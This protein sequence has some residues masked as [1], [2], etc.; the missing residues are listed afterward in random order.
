MKHIIVFLEPKDE[1]SLKRT[2]YEAITAA[3]QTG[4][5]ITGFAVSGTETALQSAA[6]YGLQKVVWLSIHFLI[7]IPQ[8]LFLKLY[9]NLHH[10]FK[11]IQF[12]FQQMPQEKKLH[13]ELALS[14]MQ[15]YSRL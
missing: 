6:E 8:Q 9:P 13:L 10:L 14:C 1:H 4:A 12:L 11:Q 7:I 5:D 2:S 3:K 15:V